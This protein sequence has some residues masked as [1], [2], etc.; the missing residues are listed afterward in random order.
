[1]VVKQRHAGLTDCVERV[2]LCVRNTLS[3]LVL[4]QTP[5]RVCVVRP[6][7]TYRMLV[8]LDV[9]VKSTF[10]LNAAARENILLS[11][12]G[13]MWLGEGHTGGGDERDAAGWGWR[14]E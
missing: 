3:V 6:V 5:T 2:T 10:W 14:V 8:T 7:S 1:M 4:V 12:A 11:R 13:R 9:S